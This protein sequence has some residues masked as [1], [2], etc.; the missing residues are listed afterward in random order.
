MDTSS[1][2]TANLLAI[3]KHI[4]TKCA[5]VNKAW[6][7]CKDKNQDPQHCIDVGKEVLSCTHQLCVP[8]STLQPPLGMHPG[9]AVAQPGSEL[10][11]MLRFSIVYVS[12]FA[13]AR[14]TYREMN[15]GMAHRI[16]W[17]S[18]GQSPQLGC[19]FTCRYTDLDKRAHATLEAYTKCLDYNTCVSACLTETRP[20]A[21]SC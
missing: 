20:P 12:S 15:D 19:F 17:I 14:K 1:L 5:G 9:S 4:A 10:V 21:G 11:K 6:L 7:D 3:H 16:L 8:L 2:K 18:H 13:L